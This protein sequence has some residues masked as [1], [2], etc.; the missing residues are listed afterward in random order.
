MWGRAGSKKRKHKTENPLKKTAGGG[1][2]KKQS[3]VMRGT[4]RE[5]WLMFQLPYIIMIM[6]MTMLKYTFGLILNSKLTCCPLCSHGYC[7]QGIWN[8]C[9]LRTT[10]QIVCRKIYALT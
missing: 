1:G 7:F 6:I 10:N 3:R 9:S 4:N 8:R 2:K 5:G